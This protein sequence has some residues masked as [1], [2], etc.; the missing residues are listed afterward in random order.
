MIMNR[1]SS[2][3]VFDDSLIMNVQSDLI[4]TSLLISASAMP[5]RW[6]AVL[7][8]FED[9]IFEAVTEL[10]SSAPVQGASAGFGVLRHGDAQGS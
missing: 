5:R 7:C 10:K 6:C 8:C 2:N 4:V 3:T 1:E 9:L